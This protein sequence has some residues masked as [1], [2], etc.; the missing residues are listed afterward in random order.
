MKYRVRPI[1]PEMF[2]VEQDVGVFYE[3]WKYHSCHSTKQEAEAQAKHLKEL[4]EDYLA[5]QKADIDFQKANPP[6]EV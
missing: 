1:N 5:K 3:R 2:Y 6:Y 4:H